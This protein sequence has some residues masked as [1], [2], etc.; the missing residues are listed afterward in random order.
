MVIVSPDYLCP[1]P[2]DQPPPEPP[3]PPEPLQPR[4]DDDPPDV[5]PADPSV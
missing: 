1:A 4:A 3:Y 2:E 5:L